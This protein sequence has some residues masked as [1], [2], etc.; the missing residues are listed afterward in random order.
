MHV[1]AFDQ[2]IICSQ[3][4]SCVLMISTNATSP[5]PPSRR[6][7][8]RHSKAHLLPNGLPPLPD[9]S[10]LLLDYPPPQKLVSLPCANKLE[11]T[12]PSW[13][14]FCSTAYQMTAHMSSTMT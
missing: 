11:W 1:Y 8:R 14:L 5:V 13:V 12:Q 6:N 2:C 10:T 3:C 7:V 9:S 4:T